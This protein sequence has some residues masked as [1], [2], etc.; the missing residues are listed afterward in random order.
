MEILNNLINGPKIS[1]EELN[2]LQ[3][4]KRDSQT[5]ESK[6]EEIRHDHKDPYV[7]I[8]EATDNS[9]GWGNASE[10]I[11]DYKETSII[12]ADNGK[13]VESLERFKQMLILGSKNSVIKNN[14]NSEAHIGKFGLGLP[15][16]SMIICDKITVVSN[17]NSNGEIMTAIADWNKMKQKNTFTYNTRFATDEEI[18]QFKEL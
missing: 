1:A 15:K 7:T 12:I 13:G 5:L 6:I 10:I 2:E 9:Y 18:Q 8:G 17:I 14:S 16:G 3:D 4:F 11:I